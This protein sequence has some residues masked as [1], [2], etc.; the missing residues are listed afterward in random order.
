MKK[1]K[2]QNWSLEATIVLAIFIV[3]F[4]LSFSYLTFLPKSDSEVLRQDSQQIISVLKNSLGLIKDSDVDDE[5]LKEIDELNSSELAELLGVS[6]D[7]CIILTDVDGNVITLEDG[8]FGVGFN[9]SLVC[10]SG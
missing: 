2:A 9:N 7:V 4:V 1:G 6:G 3:I 5:V 8:S 10:G